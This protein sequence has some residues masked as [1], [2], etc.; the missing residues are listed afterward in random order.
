MVVTSSFLAEGPSIGPSTPLVPTLHF[1]M[2]LECRHARFRTPPRP[3][4]SLPRSPHSAAEKLS[5]GAHQGCVVSGTG[6][7]TLHRSEFHLHATS[8]RGHSLSG[9]PLP[10]RT[11]VRSGKYRAT[12]KLVVHMRSEEAS[13]AM[14]KSAAA[15]IPPMATVPSAA[16]SAWCTCNPHTKCILRT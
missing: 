9:R 3:R 4:R 6:V 12:L 13:R 1:R 15:R 16:C 8:P 14:V 5:G 11:S 10:H 2:P 7:S